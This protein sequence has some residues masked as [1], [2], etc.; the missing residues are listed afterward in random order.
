MRGYRGG[1]AEAC[2]AY[3]AGHLSDP[4]F[5]RSG[6]SARHCRERFGFRRNALVVPISRSRHAS[7]LALL[8]LVP[9]RLRHHAAPPAPAFAS[10]RIGVEV[11][12]PGPTWC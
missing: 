6:I 12:A 7:L 10:D 4:S 3:T 9:L 5:Q 2:A 11:L 1:T 8:L